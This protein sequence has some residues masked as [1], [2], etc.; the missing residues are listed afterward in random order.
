MCKAQLITVGRFARSTF[1]NLISNDA[2]RTH[3][4]G[5]NGARIQDVL[6]VIE[7]LISCRCAYQLL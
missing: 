2:F 4:I 3:Q 5:K 7:S 1:P 6:S